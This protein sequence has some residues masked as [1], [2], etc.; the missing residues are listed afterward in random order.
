MTVWQI[1]RSDIVSKADAAQID[2]LFCVKIYPRL[3]LTVMFS[4]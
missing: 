3:S 4:W 2:R 1:L